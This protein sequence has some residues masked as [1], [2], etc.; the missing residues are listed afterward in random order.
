[1]RRPRHYYWLQQWQH[2]E[3]KSFPYLM[4]FACKQFTH[5]ARGVRDHLHPAI[6][7]HFIWRGRFRWT[8]DGKRYTVKSGD[9]FIT[10]PWQKHGDVGGVRSSGTMSWFQIRPASAKRPLR[11]GP[12]AALSPGEMKAV[13]AALTK[14]ESPLVRGAHVLADVIEEAYREISR[15]EAGY[16]SRF[17]YLM[18]DILVRLARM[19]DAGTGDDALSAAQFRKKA[20]LIR[21]SIDRPWTI[22]QAAKVFGV[23]KKALPALILSRTGL[24]P[25]AY[26][27]SLRIGEAMKMLRGKRPI[28]D[29]AFATGFSSQQHFS[30]YF[31]K[32]AGC[33]PRDY[34]ALYA[35]EAQ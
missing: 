21:R 5:A 32:A 4:D 25:H 13:T 19:A 12:W 7:V 8:A 23:T 14:M 10:M 20:K 24:T 11:L 35:E 31:R 30:M 15:R 29:I 6:E 3:L 17:N 28:S 2:D 16:R 26:I 9:A 1:M 22:A 33:T 18:T 27:M 34:R